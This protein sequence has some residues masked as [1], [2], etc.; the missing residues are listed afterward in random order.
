MEPA[1]FWSLGDYAI[2]G[3][4]WAQAGR[5]VVASLPVHGAQVIDL[6]TGTGVAALTA[7]EH[8]AE[9]VTGIDVTPNLLNEARRRAVDAGY[10]IEW[11]EADMHQVPLPADSADLVISTFG[12]VFSPEPEEAL[13][14]A[15]R[16]V[17]SGGQLIFT[18]WSAEGLF[19]KVRQTLASY[20]PKAP[21]PWHETPAGIQTV[22]G[23][24]AEVETRRFPIEVDSPEQFVALLETHSAPILMGKQSLGPQWASARATLLETI[25]TLAQ[26]TRYGCQLDVGY[27]VTT[28]RA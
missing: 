15:Q 17:R 1:E 24:N 4:L 5:D 3:D 10:D 23:D 18:S 12:L 25:S 26:P 11:I 6:A 13:I 28:L 14:E 22:A 19:G 27:L 20:F 8:G 7:A 21:E 9:Q 2:V 16:L